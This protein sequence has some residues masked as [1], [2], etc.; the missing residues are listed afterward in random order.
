MKKWM[1]TILELAFFIVCL[2]LIIVH[3]KTV[4]PV[5]LLWMLAGICGLIGLLYVYNRAHR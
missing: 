1:M 2:A 3:R 5:H 4:G